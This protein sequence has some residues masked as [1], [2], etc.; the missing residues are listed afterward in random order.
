MQRDRR[1][2]ERQQ[3]GW[4]VARQ[5]AQVL[6]QTFGVKQVKLFGSMLALPRIHPESDVDL[7]VGGLADDHYL[8]AVAQLLDLSE[9][10]VDLIQIEHAAPKILDAINQHGV[11]L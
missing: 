8:E 3:Q 11:D 7:A 6:K 2:R 10:S 4:Q 5:A 9:L 1:R